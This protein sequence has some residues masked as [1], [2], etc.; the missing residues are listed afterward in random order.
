[1]RARKSTA[2]KLPK[3]PIW[4]GRESKACWK[5][6]QCR[7]WL[8]LST[9]VFKNQD[10]ISPSSVFSCPSYP[11]Q[12]IARQ[13]KP[14]VV[15]GGSCLAVSYPNVPSPGR[16]VEIGKPIGRDL[17]CES[18]SVYSLLMSRQI[19]SSLLRREIKEIINGSN[20]WSTTHVLSKWRANPSRF[21]R[22]MDTW[23]VFAYM[24][25]LCERRVNRGTRWDK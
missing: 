4:L 21:R 6:S 1:M 8:T 7:D 16:L 9:S 3:L 25:L 23:F 13:A 2:I 10:L 24:F 20:Q 22:S 17:F 19:R 14:G 12:N 11:N 5:V 18:W 15:T